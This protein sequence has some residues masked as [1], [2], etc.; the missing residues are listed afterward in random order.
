[1]EETARV[2]HHPLIGCGQKGRRRGSRVEYQRRA[3][4]AWGGDGA[5]VLVFAHSGVQLD[6]QSTWQSTMG[7]DVVAVNESATGVLVGGS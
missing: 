4:W 1:M 3:Q 2:D 7:L 6:G 5:P